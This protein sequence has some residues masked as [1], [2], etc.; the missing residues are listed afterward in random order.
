MKTYFFVAL[1]CLLALSPIPAL[2]Q[3]SGT[4]LS[5]SASWDDET[6]I[7]GTVTLGLV[8]IVGADSILATKTLSNGRASVVETLAGTTLYNITLVSPSGVQF[9]KFPITTAL[10]NPQNLSTAQIHVVLRKADNS[11]KFAHISVSMG[12]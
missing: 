6:P 4:T 10:I 8:H 11:L 7:D 12:F 1:L 9:L 2:A 5:I 3:S